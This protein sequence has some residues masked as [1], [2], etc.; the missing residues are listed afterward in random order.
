MTKVSNYIELTAGRPAAMI[1][2]SISVRVA[3][4]NTALKFLLP[5]PRNDVTDHL[6][7][8][9]NKKNDYDNKNTDDNSEYGEAASAIS[10][11]L[12]CQYNT[13]KKKKQKQKQ[14]KKTSELF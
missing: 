2:N 6:E 8:V 1:R 12:D 4:W 14:N 7:D 13:M 5:V 3:L 9:N 11:R 10:A